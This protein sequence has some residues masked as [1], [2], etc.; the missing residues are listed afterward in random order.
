MKLKKIDVLFNNWAQPNQGYAL[1]APQIN[2]LL[3]TSGRTLW[4]G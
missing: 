2:T 1:Y 3:A 4:V